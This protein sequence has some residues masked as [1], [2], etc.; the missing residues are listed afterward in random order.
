[1]TY[2]R[3]I[4]QAGFVL[5]GRKQRSRMRL[6][7]RDRA[8]A[9]RPHQQSVEPRADA[10]RIERRC[11]RGAGLAHGAV[12]RC[13]RRGRLD[14]GAGI[15]YRLGRAEARA[16][17][18]HAGALPGL[19]VWRR[20]I[21]DGD[22]HG[23]R[24]GR[25]SRRG[26]RPR[27]RRYLL[28]GDAGDALPGRGRQGPGQAAHRRHAERT[29]RTADPRRGGG[30]GAR[31]RVTLREPRPRGSRTAPLDL[32]WERFWTTYTAHDRR[33]RP[34]RTSRTPKR[35]SAAP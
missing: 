25:L 31:R 18:R 27:A 28:H 13:Q 1:M 29:G 20:H 14:P 6:V 9:V 12:R 35:W 21:P 19:L 17:P 5:L 26:R 2:T 24:D 33:P 4:E 7:P 11:R 10:R 22:P 16:R 8:D 3:R 32:D 23:A 30:R 34:P 15:P